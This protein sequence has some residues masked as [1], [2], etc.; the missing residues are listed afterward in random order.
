[1]EEELIRLKLESLKGRIGLLEQ[2]IADA[3]ENRNNFNPPL[4]NAIVTGYGLKIDELEKEA[5]GYIDR[6]NSK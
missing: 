5:Q 6:L 1:M 3:K 4:R 2:Y